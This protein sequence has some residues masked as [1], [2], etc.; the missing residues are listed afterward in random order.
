VAGDYRGKPNSITRRSVD[1]LID[2]LF[3]KHGVKGYQ[4]KVGRRARQELLHLLYDLKSNV[5]NLSKK[6]KR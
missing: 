4:P 2:N 5:D 6:T 3:H 1:L